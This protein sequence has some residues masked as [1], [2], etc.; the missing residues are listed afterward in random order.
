MKITIRS[1]K[2]ACQIVADA[3]P[4]QPPPLP[5]NNPTPTL[6]TYTYTLELEGAVELGQLVSI[7]IKWGVDVKTFTPFCYKYNKKYGYSTW[8]WNKYFGGGVLSWRKKKS[9]ARILGDS[10]D[11]IGIWTSNSNLN[12]DSAYRWFFF[13]YATWSCKLF[14]PW[15]TPM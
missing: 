6:Q 15:A 8:H 9:P 3:S 11:E 10:R 7:G 4:I 13:L 1:L 2:L 12:S 5:Y 14:D